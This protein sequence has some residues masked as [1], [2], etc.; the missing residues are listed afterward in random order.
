LVIAAKAAA[1]RNEPVPHILFGGPPGTGKTSM[2]SALASFLDVPFFVGDA[3]SMKTTEDF[4]SF[5]EKFPLDGYD[6]EGNVIGEII[7]P[8][9]FLDEIHQLSLK[10]QEFLGIA[11]EN[12]RMAITLKGSKLKNKKA[13]IWLPRFTIVGATTETG[14]LSKPLRDRFKIPCKFSIYSLKESCKI[15]LAHAK[16]TDFGIAPEAV[17]SIAKRA[18]GVPRLIVRYLER[19]ID[20]TQVLDKSEVS[21]ELV[22]A[23][24]KLL[25]IDENGFTLDDVKLLTCLYENGQI[26]LGLDSLSVLLNESPRT[27]SNEVEPYLIQKGYLVRT[28]QGR[29]LSDLGIGY[30]EKKLGRS[31][32]SSPGISK[33]IIPTE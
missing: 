6:E 1:S 10:S 25:D 20:Y 2:A 8:V 3:G 29:Q 9:I 18:R 26:P 12:W 16:R 22:E 28:G 19:A 13:L 24:F 31:K 33:L 17:L 7:P 5:V 14:K 30:I 32:D 4:L 27:L 11:M 15:V 21:Y 23:M